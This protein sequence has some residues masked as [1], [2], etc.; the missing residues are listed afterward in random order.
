VPRDSLPSS[1]NCPPLKDMS[2]RVLLSASP[3]R[4]H[5]TTCPR[6]CVCDFGLPPTRRNWPIL[7]LN[8]S[9]HA[10]EESWTGCCRSRKT[11]RRMT[12][13]WHGRRPLRR[14]AGYHSDNHRYIARSVT[15]SSGFNRTARRS[16]TQEQLS[17]LVAPSSTPENVSGQRSTTMPTDDRRRG[18]PSKFIHRQ[19]V[20]RPC[21]TLR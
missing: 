3:L 4:L 14:S 15:T 20:C 8:K 18:V 10:Y 16:F 17:D 9:P 11:A 19:I 5:R 6:D 7:K 13:Y 2:V 1:I 12:M 21:E